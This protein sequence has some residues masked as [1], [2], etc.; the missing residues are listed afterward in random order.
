MIFAHYRVDGTG[1]MGRAGLAERVFGVSLIIFYLTGSRATKVGKELKAQL[2]DGHQAAGY[3]NA[4]QVFSNSLSAF[5]ASLL[6]SALFVPNSL[7]SGL[8]WSAVPPQAAYDFDRWCPLTPPASS[9][10]SRVLLFVTLG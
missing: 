2:E 5:V 6:W 8:L 10:T 7:A 4:T 9:Q 1:T 3:R